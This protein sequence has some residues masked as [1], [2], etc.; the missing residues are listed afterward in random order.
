MW[1]PWATAWGFLWGESMKLQNPRGVVLD[2]DDAEKVA[3]MLAGGWVPVD[4]APVEAPVV[5]DVP[6]EVEAEE[7]ADAPLKRGPGRPRKVPV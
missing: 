6:A 4:A 2:V 5:P 7:A 1:H 3:R